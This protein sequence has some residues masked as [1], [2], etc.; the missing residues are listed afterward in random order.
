MTTDRALETAEA[1]LHEARR[2][3]ARIDRA[4]GRTSPRTAEL[5]EALAVI[6]RLREGFR[7]R[8]A[9]RWPPPR[10]HTCRAR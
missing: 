9:K 3:E 1:E 2:R 6:G 7:P 4:S 10:E 8:P 5:S